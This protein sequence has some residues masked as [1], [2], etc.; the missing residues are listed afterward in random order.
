MSTKA[1]ELTF[2]NCGKAIDAGGRIC[3]Y[4]KQSVAISTLTEDKEINNSMDTLQQKFLKQGCWSEI[5]SINA[6]KI[7]IDKANHQTVLSARPRLLQLEHTTVC[8]AECIMC[9]HYITKNT[10][11]C[12]ISRDLIHKLEPIYPYLDAMILNGYGE[13]FLVPGI[14]EFLYL[15]HSYGIHLSA[16]TNLSFLPKH[17]IKAVT[18]TFHSLRISCDGCT[19]EVYE[20]IRRGLSFDRFVENAKRLMREAPEL[21]KTMSVVA[22]RQNVHQL[23]DMVQFAYD[24]GFSEIT[25]S[26]LGV[27]PLLGNE[28]DQLILYPLTSAQAYDVARNMG[29]K[30][31][32]SV[33]TP[34][35]D[36]SVDSSLENETRRIQSIPMFPKAGHQEDSIQRAKMS[37]GE[38]AQN[39]SRWSADLIDCDF[40]TNA[41][42]CKGI[43]EWVLEQPYID[44]H[45]NVYV[46]G[47]A[48]NYRIGNVFE[49]SDFMEI[50]NNSVIQKIRDMFYKNRLPLFCHNCQCIVNRT[51]R[52][53]SMD[54]LP[55]R[56]FDKIPLGSRH[57][58]MH[59]IK[60]E[61]NYV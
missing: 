49:S 60:R 51:L 6:Q 23:S 28:H 17:L 44:L 57:A 38:L 12:H 4:C 59:N 31:G 5:K 7:A 46:C 18:D 3:K 42:E 29:E 41:L 53:L 54:S 2:P 39:E 16:N 21:Q 52:D 9:S 34:K 1:V 35:Y 20:G 36:L 45:G 13:P 55:Q 26:R 33:V 30:L 43:C 32:I 15:Y 22:M 25:F 24:L 56:F 48:P 50:W 11:T 47:M 19:A 37:T 61:I 40:S 58:S 8:N 14:E 10:N 27:N